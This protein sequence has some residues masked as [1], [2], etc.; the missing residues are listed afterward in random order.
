MRPELPGFRS[1][2]LLV[3]AIAAVTLATPGF[4]R[5]DNQHGPKIDDRVAEAAAMTSSTTPIPVIVFGNQA[6][7]QDPSL[8]DQV[9]IGIATAGTVEAGQLDAIAADPNV[10]FVAPDIAI[11]PLV[12]PSRATSPSGLKALY[13]LVDDALAA[14]SAGYAGNGIGIA[15]VDSGVDFGSLGSRL[16]ASTGAR[17][18]HDQ[19]GHG[20]LVAHFAAGNLNGQWVGIAPQANVVDVTVGGARNNG[21]VYTSD[22][23]GGLMWVL[24]HKDE[25]NIRIVNLS[26]VETMPSSYT[27]SVLDSVVELLWRSG[28]VVV[29]AA[30][31]TGPGTEQFAPANDPFAITVG[32]TDSQGTADPSDDTVTP[33]SSSG[34]TPDGVL[35]PDLVA[36][37]RLVT[38][39]L[40]PGTV[41]AQ[42]APAQNWV[43]DRIVAINGTSFSAPQ[44]A[45]AAADVLQAHPDWTPDQ[46]KADLEGAGRAQAGSTAP[47]LDVSAAVFTQ[48]SP[49]PANQGV[50]YSDFGLAQWVSTLLTTQAGL[51]G[52]SGQAGWTNLSGQASWT[53]LSGQ[54]GWTHLSGQA[55]WTGAAAQASWTAY[56]QASW[57]GMAWG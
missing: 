56:G 21:S 54:A 36:P 55:S 43:A 20:T 1:I 31:N 47:A 41:L 8:R 45:G 33:W 50:P 49:A 19:L 51:G 34:L 29:T 44:V 6:A 17:N 57:T 46:V 9:D 27:A 42:E 53:H 38:G 52:M 5:A 37:G 7:K 40:P 32:A 22:V 28:I 18:G 3:G 24:A 30:G 16:V 10:A 39:Y 4:A 15:V 2:L 13:P 26:L 14:W 48:G 35:K 25:F 23:V 12:R 11:A